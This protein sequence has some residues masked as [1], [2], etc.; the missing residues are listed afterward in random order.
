MRINLNES[1]ILLILGGLDDYKQ[2]IIRG[3]FGQ[4][5]EMREKELAPVLSLQS[6]M[7]EILKEI[8]KNESFKRS[9]FCFK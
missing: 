3:L 9:D 5:Q 8:I 4:S 7:R 6:K 1:E 2:G